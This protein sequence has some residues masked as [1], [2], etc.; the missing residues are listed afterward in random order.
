MLVSGRV[1]VT[2]NLPKIVTNHHV[3]NTN[4][5]LNIFEVQTMTPK[6]HSLSSSNYLRIFGNGKKA[7]RYSPNSDYQLNTVDL[8]DWLWLVVAKKIQ[9]TSYKFLQHWWI[10]SSQQKIRPWFPFHIV[11]W[12]PTSP[13]HTPCQVS[14]K[15]GAFS[16]PGA[17]G[18]TTGCRHGKLR[19]THTASNPKIYPITVLEK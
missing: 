4:G 7:K 18:G 10:E 9:E 17:M 8:L 15:K 16:V 1:Q 2:P 13:Y 3:C 12:F 11:P 14:D 19:S 5:N 6:F